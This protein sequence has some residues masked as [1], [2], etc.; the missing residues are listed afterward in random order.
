MAVFIQLLSAVPPPCIGSVA[1]YQVVPLVVL[2][3]VAV[4]ARSS[5]MATLRFRPPY[6]GASCPLERGGGVLTTHS[7]HS[8]VRSQSRLGQSPDGWVRPSGRGG[9]LG[10]GLAW[11][12]LA[13]GWPNG[14][15][16]DCWPNGCLMAGQ[17]AGHGLG[18]AGGG[19]KRGGEPES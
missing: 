17:M 1:G 8:P 10:H 4:H 16:N 14:W 9:N 2:G 15:P 3:I 18:E 11:V 7:L 12:R 19:T 5:A 6:V 13:Y